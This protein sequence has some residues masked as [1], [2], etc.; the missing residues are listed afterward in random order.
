MNKLITQVVAGEK[1]QKTAYQS[2]TINHGIEKIAVLIP[3]SGAAV[4]EQNFVQLKDKSK[5][6]LLELVKSA[7]GK[8][9]G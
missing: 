3:L 2:Y 8:M 1:P 6:A 9:K 5:R 4:F 7:G